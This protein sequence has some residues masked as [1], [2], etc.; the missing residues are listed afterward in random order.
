MAVF[1]YFLGDNAGKVYK[2]SSSAV[3]DDTTAITCQYV[4]VRTDLGYPDNF[5]TIHQIRLYYIDK[6]AVSVAVSLSSS[7][8]DTAVSEWQSVTHTVG[9]AGAPGTI[10]T[11][12]YGFIYTGHL[13]NFR[14]YHSATTGTFQWIR[15]EV[16]F[17]VGGPILELST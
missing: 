4:T 8:G 13:F 1:D 6:G 15:M 3:A 11:K 12:E 14:I 17:E 7:E 16:E 2:F 5:K 10:K 9:T